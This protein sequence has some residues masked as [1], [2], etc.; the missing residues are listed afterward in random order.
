MGKS[1]CDV[2]ERANGR[3]VVFGNHAATPRS[4]T[5]RSRE[6]AEPCG[7]AQSP[8]GIATSWRATV[9]PVSAVRSR[10]AALLRSKRA[11]LSITA[12]QTVLQSGV[13]KESSQ[14]I[15]AGLRAMS[16]P[17]LVVALAS[18]TERTPK[19][20]SATR[21]FATIMRGSA[22]QQWIRSSVRP[23]PVSH[24][25]GIIGRPPL[26]FGVLMPSQL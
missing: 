8:F 9:T 4:R 16:Q 10:C 26:A 7:E 11:I 12:R 5:A 14:S 6:M 21:T 22:C 13:P 15:D 2:G 17:I 19:S 3:A 23:S 18:L 24:S 25:L 20:V 1:G